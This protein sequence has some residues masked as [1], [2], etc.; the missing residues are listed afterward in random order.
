MKKLA[1]SLLALLMVLFTACGNNTKKNT[2]QQ[3]IDDALYYVKSGDFEKAEEYC[4]EE[5]ELYEFCAKYTDEVMVND[6]RADEEFGSAAAVIEESAAWKD[7]F[8]SLRKSMLDD[9]EI[10]SVEE[11]GDSA[12]A[13]VKMR[14]MTQEFYDSLT[15]TL[16]TL[17][18]QSM[19]EYVAANQEQLPEIE[20]I[21]DKDAL[22]A[23]IVRKI[24][25]DFCQ[26]AKDVL[27][28]Y[29]EYEDAAADVHLTKKDGKWLIDEFDYSA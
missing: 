24:S 29:C 20:D 22:I 13:S 2:P 4:T 1:V 25:T 6:L 8:V 17:M 21:E 11:N 18:A 5:S 9:Y 15:E 12:T 16:T 10:V 26:K 23:E 3:A 14:C 7:M 27:S 19:V 28:T